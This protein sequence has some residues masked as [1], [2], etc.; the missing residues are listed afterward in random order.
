MWN[1]AERI[2]TDQFVSCGTSITTNSLTFYIPTN[3]VSGPLFSRFRL[4]TS[5]GIGLT[6]GA[7][8]GEVEDHLVE[9]MEAQ[10]VDWGDAPDTFQ[11]LIYPTLAIHT[12]A[13]HVV[14]HGMY[15]GNLVDAEPDGQPNLGCT[16]DDNDILYPSMGDD[17]DGVTFTTQLQPG[18][19]ARI[20]VIA[21]MDGK[22]DAW[23]DFN[24]DAD[25]DDSGERI[26]TGTGLSA[27]TNSLLFGVPLNSVTGM[28]VVSRF[29]YSLSGVSSYS[30]IAYSGE[31]EDYLVDIEPIEQQGAQDWGDAPNSFPVV[32]AAGGARHTIVAGIV[33][34]A[35]IDAE[36][37]GQPSAADGDDLNL[38]YPGYVDDE[39]G[40]TFAT[41]VVAGTNAYIDV[42]A[43]VS[44]GMLDAWIDFN[45]DG[46]WSPGEHLFG[47]V[48]VPLAPGLNTGVATVKVPSPPALVLGPSVARFRISSAGVSGPG[49]AASDG[50]VEDYLVDL[51]QPQMSTN[52][53]IT[54]FYFNVSNTY[55]TVEWNAETSSVYQLQAST[56]LVVTNG[57]IDVETQVIGPTNWQTNSITA[58]SNKFY[59]VTAPWTE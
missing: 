7:P 57:W 22:L 48:A 49:G 55:A 39:D 3:A 20:E 4:S 9:I 32:L 46:T 35:T 10:E 50:E 33:L 25:W 14:V 21:S 28:P 47:G 36:P 59:R 26:F 1:A 6:G 18:G 13:H 44:G 40:V 15:L 51:Y 17:E 52:L 16:G 23:I 53:V 56:N 19:F 41:K 31:V 54:N 29:R 27:G 58:E 30:G 38:L 5:T 43:G 34:G 45:A 12:G 42:V 11:S 2:F 37:D 8:D 24:N